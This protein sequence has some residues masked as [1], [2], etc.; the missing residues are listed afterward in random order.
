MKGRSWRLFL[1]AAVSAALLAMASPAWADSIAYVKGSTGD[2]WIAHSDGSSQRQVTHGGGY[3]WPSEADS[4]TIVALGPGKTAPDGTRGMDIYKMDQSGGQIGSRIPTPSD[5]SDSN[6]PAYPPNNVRVSP[7]G[8]KIAYD[9]Y[10]CGTFTTYWTPSSSTGLNWP[11]QTLGQEDYG[12]PFWM[13]NSNLLLTHLGVPWNLQD[14]FTTYNTSDGDNSSQSWFG[15]TTE[16]DPSNPNGWATGFNAAISR[17]DNKLAIYEDDAADYFDGQPRTV[18][19]RLFTTN[20]APPAQ[21]TFRCQ[22]NLPASKFPYGTSNDSISFSPDGNQI[23]WE[24]TDGIHTANIGDLSDCSAITQKLLISG[25]IDPFWS[26]ANAMVP[27]RIIQPSSRFQT[28]KSFTVTWGGSGPYDVRYNKARYNGT[29]GSYTMWQNGTTAKS[30]S[31][32]GSP[33]NTYCFEAKQHGTVTWSAQRCTS[34]PLDDTSLAANGFVRKT[35]SAYY[36]GTYS[37]S[38]TKGATLTRTGAYGRYLAVMASTS[39]TGGTIRVSFKG[40]PVGKVSLVSTTKQTKRLFLF[41][42]GA[43][44]SGTVSIQVLTSGKRVEIDGLGVSQL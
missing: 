17:Q 30:A 5:Y 23:A 6:C 32:T 2:V 38:S 28:A 36:L 1:L 16:V 10:T 13:D 41:N 14:T 35:G 15:D 8:N 12:D 40:S 44:K 31:F 42:L 20:G 29:F 22:I 3:A 34:V 25:G 11:N 26:A 24:D 4:G 7:D 43:V 19:I 21:P 39:P 37:L 33:G 27:D 9:N 18:A